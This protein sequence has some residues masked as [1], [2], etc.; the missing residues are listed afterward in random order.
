MTKDEK[1]NLYY[2]AFACALLMIVGFLY[3][4]SNDSQQQASLINDLMNKESAEAKAKKPKKYSPGEL[5]DIHRKYYDENL[6][7]GI[8]IYDG[9]K[10]ILHESPSSIK[11]C[12]WADNMFKTY[13]VEW[14][15]PLKKYSS[16][17]CGCAG[18]KKYSRIDAPCTWN[19]NADLVAWAEKGY[20]YK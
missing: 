14:R 15:E 11:D 5:Y 19:K 2:G 18:Y 10:F 12:A 17:V 7:R 4:N 16:F 13:H 6:I 3:N 8:Y 1:K 20:P 9:R